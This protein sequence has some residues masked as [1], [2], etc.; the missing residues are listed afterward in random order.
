MATI[1]PSA[2]ETTMPSPGGM[3]RV[4]SRKNQTIKP[5][6]TV[7]TAMPIPVTIAAI[8]CHLKHTAQIANRMAEPKM[9][10]EKMNNSA[11]PVRA[12]GMLSRFLKGSSCGSQ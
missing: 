11:S 2:G 7:S 12:N 6:I 4:G 1:F 10:S 5:P 3:G 9:S 8:P